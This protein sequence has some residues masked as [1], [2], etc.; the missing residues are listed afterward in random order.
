MSRYLDVF[1]EKVIFQCVKLIIGFPSSDNSK[2]I[3]LHYS[4]EY[5]QRES[6]NTSREKFHRLC[7]RVGYEVL[8]SEKLHKFLK[9]TLI[10]EI[11]DKIIEEDEKLEAEEKAEI[12]LAAKLAVDAKMIA[13][14]S[15]AKRNGKATARKPVAKKSVARKP[16]A[17]AA[18]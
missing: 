4:A 11:V 2:A 15:S 5:Y 18:K 8:S 14:K 10:P 13:P 16:A 1:R 9:E 3:G 7:A 6:F 12:A 17:K